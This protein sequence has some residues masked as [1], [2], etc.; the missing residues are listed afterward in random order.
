M[1]DIS[2]RKFEDAIELGL[3]QHGPDAPAAAGV[4]RETL[5]PYGDAPG[6]GTVGGGPRT[7]TARSDCSRA[8]SWTSSSRPSR[9]RGRS[10]PSTTARR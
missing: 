7:T 5:S 3:L 6:G 2:E 4:A 8:T 1:M 10:W 9:V